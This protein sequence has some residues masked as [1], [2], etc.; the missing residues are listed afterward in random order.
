MNKRDSRK[1]R[2]AK[3][4]ARIA[5]Q[6]AARLVVFRS[7]QHIYAQVV[8][9]TDKGDKVLATS[10]TLDKELKTTIT[11][12]KVEQAFQVGKLL[13]QRAKKNKVSKIAFDRAGYK[14]HGRVESLAKGAREAGLEF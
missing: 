4:K 5:R 14:Y 3:T 11:G 10:S 6:N 13:G 8:V 7:A 9:H 12:N 2:A 1:R